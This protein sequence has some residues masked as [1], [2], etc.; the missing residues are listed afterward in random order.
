M[1]KV[2]VEE[3]SGDF[4]LNIMYTSPDRNIANINRTFRD[5]NDATNYTRKHFAG[6]VIEQ[7]KKYVAHADILFNTS[8]S[9]F[10]AT[11]G[12]RN[13]LYRLQDLLEVAHHET[14]RSLVQRVIALERDILNILPSSH[15]K[16][17]QSSHDRADDIIRQCLRYYKVFI[18]PT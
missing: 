5:I 15:N 13:S 4:V 8:G 16:S 17:Y 7:L 1:Y 14:T 11:E 6:W 2:H 9:G 10:Y 18:K 12:K 3:Q